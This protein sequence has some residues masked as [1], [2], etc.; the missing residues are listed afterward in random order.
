MKKLK[1]LTKNSVTLVV[2]IW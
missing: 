1:I 2:A